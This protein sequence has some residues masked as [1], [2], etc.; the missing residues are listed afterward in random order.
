M[1]STRA[2]LR[3]APAAASSHQYL[4]R[5][6]HIGGRRARLCIPGMSAPTR[7]TERRANTA[8]PSPSPPYR[9][10]RGSTWKLRRC[11]E[12]LVTS[13]D[14]RAARLRFATA[15]RCHAPPQHGYAALGSARPRPS[16][17]THVSGGPK[18]STAHVLLLT[19]RRKKD[20]AVTPGAPTLARRTTNEDSARLHPQRFVAA[21][22]V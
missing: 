6:L 18:T 16:A 12:E 21:S 22:D 10:Q 15:P 5:A 1:G 7:W 8:T 11:A 9:S 17:S 19:D 4:P 2:L 14:C 3:T 13:E 20:T